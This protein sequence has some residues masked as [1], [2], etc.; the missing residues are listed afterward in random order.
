LLHARPELRATTPRHFA[1]AA[2]SICGMNQQV[3]GLR[4]AIAS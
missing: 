4:L 1:S 2:V 3:G